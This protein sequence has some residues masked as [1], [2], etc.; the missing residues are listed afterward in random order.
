MPGIPDSIVREVPE[1]SADNP[2]TSPIG[3][4]TAAGPGILYFEVPGVARYLVRNGK[5]IEFAVESGA[6]RAAAELFLRTS[7]QAAL[8]YQRRE[9]PLNATTLIAPNLQTVALSGPSATGK[10]TLAAALCLRGWLLVA[11][12]I[13]RIVWNG[14]AAVAWPGHGT[15]RLWRDACEMLGFDPGKLTRVRDGLEKF[16]VPVRSAATPSALGVMIRLRVSLDSDVLELPAERNV[17]LVSESSFR[18]RW[19]DPL[20]CRVQHSRVAGQIGR[21]CRGIV[22]GGARERPVQELVDEIAGLMR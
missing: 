19:I 5:T 17:Q 6:D 2:G 13:T 15:L 1:L 11:D 21:C 10:S 8:I 22:L 12:D 3:P 9:L 20:G 14:T 16:H 4:F 7:A 18:P